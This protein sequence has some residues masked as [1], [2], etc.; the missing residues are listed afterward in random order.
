VSGQ[1]G[2]TARTAAAPFASASAVAS[3]AEPSSRSPDARGRNR[4]G[5]GRGFS[6]NRRLAFYVRDAEDKGCT[7]SRTSAK[8]GMTIRPIDVAVIIGYP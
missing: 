1:R 3:A 8:N 2:D 7:T 5:G 4:R 6:F